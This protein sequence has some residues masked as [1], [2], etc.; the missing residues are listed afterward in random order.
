MG[1]VVAGGVAHA[2]EQFQKSVADDG[3]FCLDGNRNEH[4]EQF[5]VGEQHAERQ[6]D[7][8]NGSRGSDHGDIDF[9]ID[10]ALEN[11]PSRRDVFFRSR[12]VDPGVDGF[13]YPSGGSAQLRQGEVGEEGRVGGCHEPGVLLIH[14]FRFEPSHEAVQYACADAAHEVEYQEPLR[15]PHG[16]QD[17]PEHE[18]GEHVEEDVGEFDVAVWRYRG[19][20][21]HVGDILPYPPIGGLRQV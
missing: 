21:E 10:D 20:H 7:A 11:L 19:V 5:R 1:D 14:F 6:Q 4:E 15:A 13:P 2:K 3:I 16:F 12:V 9:Q 17:A 8:E 18:E